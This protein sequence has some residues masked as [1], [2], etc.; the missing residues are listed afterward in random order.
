MSSFPNKSSLAADVSPHHIDEGEA[1]AAQ[2]ETKALDHRLYVRINKKD[3]LFL[4]YLSKAEG[5]KPSQVVRA[6]VLKFLRT[7]KRET[8]G[9]LGK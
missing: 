4:E 1:E 3:Y 9:F 7:K 6:L 2:K 8:L 5:L